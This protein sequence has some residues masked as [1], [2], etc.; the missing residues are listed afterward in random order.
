MAEAQEEMNKAQ[1]ELDKADNFKLPPLQDE[2]FDVQQQYEAPQV[3]R[4]DERVMRWQDDN[5]WFG[6]NKAMTAYALGVH[7]EL[8]DSGVVVGSERY[9]AEL[10][11]TMRST[12]SNFFHEDVQEEA[13]EDSKAKPK[14]DNPKAKPMTNVAPATRSTAPKRVRLT[15]SQVAIS[16][17]LGLTP[18][19]Y[20]REL[21]KMEA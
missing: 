10:D 1:L 6:Q 21:M 16:K 11:K 14:A 17:K 2:K 3:Q 9:Y 8:R 18:E 15:Q 13:D 20:V 4:P 5:P 7:E 19:Q 12:F